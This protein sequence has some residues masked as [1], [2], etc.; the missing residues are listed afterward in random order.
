MVVS[1]DN[2]QVNTTSAILLM[3]CD[4]YL[5]RPIIVVFV[6]VVLFHY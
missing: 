5:L 2:S 1:C 4:S 3:I 6:V